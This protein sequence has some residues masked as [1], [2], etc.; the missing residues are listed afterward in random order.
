MR[1]SS[2]YPDDG[3]TGESAGAERESVYE[4]DIRNSTCDGDIPDS[5]E[6]SRPKRSSEARK[7][8]LRHVDSRTSGG[9]PVRRVPNSRYYS[10]TST[11]Y[12]SVYCTSPT[13]TAP[14][15]P[16]H[17]RQLTYSIAEGYDTRPASRTAGKPEAYRSMA[18]LNPFGS[19]PSTTAAFF[20]PVSHESILPAPL[21]LTRHSG[22]TATTRDSG[23]RFDATL[24]QRTSTT[25]TSSR[26]S[27][28]SSR[29]SD[30]PTTSSCSAQ[31]RTSTSTFEER[32]PPQTR[33]SR[34][35]DAKQTDG[36]P[37]SA[38]TSEVGTPIS[39]RK[40][41]PRKIIRRDSLPIPEASGRAGARRAPAAGARPG[42][43]SATTGEDVDGKCKKGQGRSVEDLKTVER[44]MRKFGGRRGTWID[45]TGK[46]GQK[47]V[48]IP[49]GGKKE[50]F[51][52]QVQCGKFVEPHNRGQRD[53]EWI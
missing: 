14:T 8:N 46:F 6:K 17:S 15:S 45:D 31:R 32:Y 7:A 48:P 30:K 43:P 20:H 10:R 52:R 53:W 13:D 5:R 22:S 51:I 35:S 47:I 18:N 36:W 39:E 24:S 23:S 38:R 37:S 29:R 9:F 28:N 41:S 4:D 33:G 50:D 12:D 1:A 42:D 40:L 26:S 16:V 34:T 19:P 2:V 25:T 44:F 27:R 11:Q 3:N 21:Q 49:S